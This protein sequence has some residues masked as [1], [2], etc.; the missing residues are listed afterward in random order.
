MKETC[1]DDIGYKSPLDVILE[2]TGKK[3]W[4]H[5]DSEFQ[6]YSGSLKDL[7]NQLVSIQPINR[8]IDEMDLYQLTLLAIHPTRIIRGVLE[9]KLDT[10]FIQGAEDLVNAASNLALMCYQEPAKIKSHISKFK[11]ILS[12]ERMNLL[13]KKRIIQE[14][15]ETTWEASDPEYSKKTS[16]HILDSFGNRD[17]LFIPLAYGGILSGID[18]YLRYLNSSSSKGSKFY[19]VRFSTNKLLDIEPRLCSSE[20]KYLTEAAIDREVVLFDEDA[21]TGNTIEKARKYFKEK[22]FVNKEVHAVINM[23]M[24]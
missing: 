24:R 1:P 8:S 18:S 21:Y 4:H 22:V 13:F 9:Y 7:F 11:R 20:V 16:T 19:P 17:I 10:L 14:N 3:E 2:K 15:D 12:P 5:I 23:D 6:N